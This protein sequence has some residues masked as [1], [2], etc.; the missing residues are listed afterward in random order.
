MYE[1]DFGSPG[2][3]IRTFA[4]TW[5]ASENSL[6]AFGKILVEEVKGYKTRTFYDAMGQVISY[7]GKSLSYDPWG[8]LTECSTSSYTWKASYDALGRRLQTIYKPIKGAV[9]VTN[10]Y[11]DPEKEFQEIGVE[12]NNKSFWKMYGTN[13]CDAVIDENGS[14]VQLVHNAL[15][16]L[17]GVLYEGG[18]VWNFDIPSAYGPQGLPEAIEPTLR[19]LGRNG[20]VM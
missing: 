1:F 5:K 3:G 15:N 7:S 10:S 19:G 9:V 13:S 4:S 12:V 17:I 11:Y 14:Y 20:T 2:L 18:V 8:R 16:N 6:D